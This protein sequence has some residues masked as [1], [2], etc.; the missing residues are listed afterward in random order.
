M[1]SVVA[2][3]LWPGLLVGKDE[4]YAQLLG[5][6]GWELASLPRSDGRKGSEVSMAH[7]L[8]I[9]IRQNCQVNSQVR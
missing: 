6:A 7:C 3:V 8:G 5:G 1:G 2:W 4:G 9:E